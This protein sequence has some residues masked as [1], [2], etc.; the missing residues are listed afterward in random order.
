VKL[1]TGK[2]I[3]VIKKC[4]NCNERSGSMRKIKF[5]KYII[6][7]YHGYNKSGL[8]KKREMP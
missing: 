6:N 3:P 8:I 7:I 1:K 5:I 2:R 4:K